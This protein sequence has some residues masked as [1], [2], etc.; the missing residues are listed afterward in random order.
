M[1]IT[2]ESWYWLHL[3]P[4]VLFQ[5]NTTAPSSSISAC[6]HPLLTFL[7]GLM[8]IFSTFHRGSERQAYSCG[9]DGQLTCSGAACWTVWAEKPLVSG[10][11]RCWSSCRRDFAAPARSA[12]STAARLSV[13]SAHVLAW[14]LQWMKGIF[15]F[16]FTYARL[17]SNC[18]ELKWIVPYLLICSAW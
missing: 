4:S 11:S 15:E 9:F 18:T 5:N 8:F 2:N 16:G 17:I 6:I 12:C 3:A 7:P 10:S 14:K 13:S 1:R